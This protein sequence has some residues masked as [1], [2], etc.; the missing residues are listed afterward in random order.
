MPENPDAPVNLS[1][2]VATRF[3]R[4]IKR[5]EREPRPVA[6]GPRPAVPNTSVDTGWHLALLP[7]DGIDAG[8]MGTVLLFY[9]LDDL[10]STE[11]PARNPWETDAPA[12]TKCL[13]GRVRGVVEL[14]V[15][16]WDCAPY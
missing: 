2:D 11:I 16:N 8:E 4:G 15:G 5:Y 1:R 9:G 7:D 6:L 12:S 10:S 3:A 14:V 13:V